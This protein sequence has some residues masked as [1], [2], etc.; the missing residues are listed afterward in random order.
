MS[1]HPPITALSL[2]EAIPQLITLA[3][4]CPSRSQQQRRLLT[5]AMPTTIGDHYSCVVTAADLQPLIDGLRAGWF[6]ASNE[7][8]AAVSRV[9][10]ALTREIADIAVRTEY[11]QLADEVAA[12]AEVL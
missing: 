8:M 5:A 4:R 11:V 2:D 12:G 6:N 10:S 7:D 1:D 9:M 3:L